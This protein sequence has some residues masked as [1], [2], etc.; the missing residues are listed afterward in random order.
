MSIPDLF[1]TAAAYLDFVVDFLAFR[2]LA[3][4]SL[5]DSTS[6]ILVGFFSL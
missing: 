6:Y 5:Q 2:G 1:K 3:V 4:Y